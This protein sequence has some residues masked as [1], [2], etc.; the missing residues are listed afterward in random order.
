MN[1]EAFWDG[2]VCCLQLNGKVFPK[3]AAFV[4]DEIAKSIRLENNLWTHAAWEFTLVS[5]EEFAEFVKAE[6]LVAE[7][8]DGFIDKTAFGTR[9]KPVPK[10]Q[11]VCQQVFHALESI[12][13]L[14]LE[15]VLETVWRSGQ[16]IRLFYG[17][18]E[19]GEDNGDTRLYLGRLEKL[20]GTDGY[21]LEGRGCHL[22][23]R[24][25][26]IVKLTMDKKVIYQHPAY[27]LDLSIRGSRET[28]YQIY[29][30][31]VP[32]IVK[33]MNKEQAEQY[34]A[35]LMGTR[36]VYHRKGGNE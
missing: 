18:G 22:R 28:G 9:Y 17:D 23:V 36:N 26:K 2:G 7:A 32:Y 16:R 27:H 11:D 33:P 31:G 13:G 12:G 5:Y 24:N 29:K 25:T 6:G 10:I 35:F 8:A 20:W 4:L 34:A 21:R 19:T 1:V 14:S 30:N 15:Q 3:A